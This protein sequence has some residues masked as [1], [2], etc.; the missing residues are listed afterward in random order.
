VKLRTPLFFVK[1]FKYEYWTWWVFYLPLFP[2]LLSYMIRSGSF[3][4]FLSY[5]NPSMA[6]GG[7][8]GES[9]IDILNSITLE[10][11]PK[12]FFIKSNQIRQNP[13]QGVVDTERIQEVL[14]HIAKNRMNFPFVCKP[15]VGERGNNVEKINN[16]EDLK[17][18][19]TDNHGDM[20]VQEF[21]TY[22]IELGVM[23]VRLPN[24]EK[25]KVTSITMKKFLTVIGNGEAT[26][27]ELLQEN[28]RA[29]FQ[30]DRLQKRMSEKLKM[31]PQ[32]GEEVIIEPIGN[33]CRGTE[34]INRNDLIK[35][36]IHEVFDRISSTIT[37]FYYGRFDLK[38]A[39][40]DDLYT[41]K[42]IKIM[43]LNGVSS[44]PAHIYDSDYK[45]WQAYKDILYHWGL[46]WKI[47]VQNKEME[48]YNPYKS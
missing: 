8:I 33:H 10:Y 6:S 30:L 22:P 28:E 24:E 32:N 35:D 1:L 41:G 43:E 5:V 45:L 19:L 48:K 47:Y 25:G 21:I 39:N 29:R 40:F 27:Y 37:G 14:A 15:N 23:Y 11:K 17:K 26:T 36:E 38:I 46:I 9:K 2:F 31:I 44:E 34:F 18:Y 20:I 13:L 12:T 3:L 16:E 4:R 42:N 7:L